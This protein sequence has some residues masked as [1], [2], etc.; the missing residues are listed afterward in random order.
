MAPPTP[1]LGNLMSPRTNQNQPVALVTGAADRIGAAIAKAL[2]AAGWRVV[3][4]YR[5]STEK[6]R[7]TVAAIQAAGGEAAPV[8]ADLASRAQRNGLVHRRRKA[9]RDA[10]AARQQRLDIRARCRHRSRRNDLGR[11]FRRARQGTGLSEP[12]FRRAAAARRR[13][14]H[15]Q[16]HRRAG[17]R[18]VAGIFQL[19]A[20]QVRALDHDANPGAVAGPA[21]SR[22]RRCPPARP[23]RQPASVLP[24]TAAARPNCRSAAV[25]R[26]KRS[27]RRC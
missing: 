12:R 20:Q 13:G 7:E 25:P 19:H 6:A 24:A 26:L 16:H 18:S 1:Y 11:A 9:V 4:H 8:R 17:A 3:V 5:S 21:N 23:Y 14:Q 27:P 22:Q 15:R 10:D 2:A